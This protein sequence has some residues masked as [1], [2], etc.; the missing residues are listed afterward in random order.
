MV[1]CGNAN[2]ERSRS[3]QFSESG[4]ASRIN[5]RASGVDPGVPVVGIVS[6]NPSFH[7]GEKSVVLSQSDADLGP[8]LKTETHHLFN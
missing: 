3:D 4:G 7:E 2:S 8:G 5:A 1:V 6:P